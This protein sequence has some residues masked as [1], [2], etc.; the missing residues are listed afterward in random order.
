M[1]GKYFKIGSIAATAD[2]FPSVYD[3][4]GKYFENCATVRSEYKIKTGYYYI[5]EACLE[6]VERTVALGGPYEIVTAFPGSGTPLK[7]IGLAAELMSQL[8]FEPY[9]GIAPRICSLRPTAAA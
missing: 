3:P 4:Q 6:L 7:G 5:P 2:T 1:E 9:A 8:A